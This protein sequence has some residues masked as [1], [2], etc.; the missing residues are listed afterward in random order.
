MSKRTYFRTSRR[1]AEAAREAVW[2]DDLAAGR[3][4]TRIK[5]ESSGNEASI[6]AENAEDEH[7]LRTALASTG[8]HYEEGNEQQIHGHYGGI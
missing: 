7:R 3:R 5:V 2:D 1:H 6:W 4:L 8:A